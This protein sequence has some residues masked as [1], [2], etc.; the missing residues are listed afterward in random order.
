MARGKKVV[1]VN[2]LKEDLKGSPKSIEDIQIEANKEVDFLEAT[3]NLSAIGA[4]YPI[5]PLNI[6]CVLGNLVLL[7]AI[8][9]PLVSGELKQG[10]T[11]SFDDCVEA[12]YVLAK[13][14]DAIKPI[15]NISQKITDLMLLKPMAKDNPLIADKIIQKVESIS[16]ARD[17]FTESAREFWNQN[18]V[19]HQFE[20]IINNVISAIS[21]IAKASDDLPS[22]SKQKVK[23]SL[24]KKKV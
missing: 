11:L 13:G 7:S 22:N 3:L 17:E 21:D 12:I 19:G 8:E 14:K 4:K 5:G 15:M 23:K 20:E 10:D 1:N 24:T 2:A 6:K 18:F 9:S 16:K